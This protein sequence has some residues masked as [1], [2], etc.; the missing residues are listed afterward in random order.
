MDN[1]NETQSNLLPYFLPSP[2]L[3]NTPRK[4]LPVWAIVT[5]SITAVLLFCCVVSVIFAATPLGQKFIAEANATATA[6]SIVDANTHATSTAYALAHPQPTKTPILYP[7]VTPQPKLT[8]TLQP[9]STIT[10]APALTKTSIPTSTPSSIPSQTVGLGGTFSAFKARF[11][12]S[13]RGNIYFQEWDFYTISSQLADMYTS[14][15]PFGP[16]NNDSHVFEF[17]IYPSSGVQWTVSTSAAN[18]ALCNSLRPSDT[19][20][21]KSY[22]DPLNNGIVTEYTSKLLANTL[23]ASDFDRVGVFYEY[24]GDYNSG[25]VVT[26]QASFI[27]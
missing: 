27:S 24:V 20:Q 8:V 7:T 2:Q 10:P 19:Q 5:I 23:V 15:T 16:G 14:G 3:P 22:P 21:G 13:G 17:S 11:G 26:T 25:C 9:T 12:D 4:G 1:N 6:Q 18:T